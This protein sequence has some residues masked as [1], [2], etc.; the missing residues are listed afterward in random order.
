[1][2]N[3]VFHEDVLIDGEPVPH[4][5]IAGD[6]MTWAEHAV[7]VRG[8]RVVVGV[9]SEG[10]QMICEAATASGTVFDSRRSSILTV[11]RAE[12]GD[13]GDPRH[14]ALREILLALRDAEDPETIAVAEELAADAAA[15]LH[16]IGALRDTADAHEALGGG[17]RARQLIADHEAQLAPVLAELRALHLAEVA[18]AV[19]GP[20][21]VRRHPATGAA[22]RSRRAAPSPRARRARRSAAG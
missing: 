2:R 4:T 10:L 5:R 12:E 14:A 3:F 18:Q 17:A 7:Q 19:D 16:A 9:R 13:D 8:E 21:A 1:M 6:R 11:P 15:R 20:R 22:S